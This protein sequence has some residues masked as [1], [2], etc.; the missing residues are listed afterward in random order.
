MTLPCDS[1]RNSG[2]LFVPPWVSVSMCIYCVHSR[3]GG[4]VEGGAWA[5]QGGECQHCLL[6]TPKKVV[7][8]MHKHNAVTVEPPVVPVVPKPTG[9]LPP[10]AL[11]LRTPSG[12]LQGTPCTHKAERFKEEKMRKQKRKKSKVD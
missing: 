3:V 2:T 5:A 8:P 6:P 11:L 1:R 4:C 9:N 10:A 7:L 12:Y